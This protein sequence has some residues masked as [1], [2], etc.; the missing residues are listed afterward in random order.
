AFQESGKSLRHAVEHEL[1]NADGKAC[2]DYGLHVTPKDLEVAGVLEEIPELADEGFPSVKV[3]T[4]VSNYALSDRDVIRVLR[5]ARDNGLMVN[6]HAEEDSLIRSLT[7]EL[8]ERGHAGVEY[9]TAA[10]PPV[11]EAIATRRVAEYARALDTPV[12]FVHLSSREALDE[13]RR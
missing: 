2:I 4:S 7:E 1:S 8:I 12:Y 11:T 10:R 13:V 3:F 6:V 9:L 5:V